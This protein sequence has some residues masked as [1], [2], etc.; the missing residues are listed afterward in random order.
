MNE[1]MTGAEIVLKSLLERFY[2]ISRIF[3]LIYA[4]RGFP[5]YSCTLYGIVEKPAPKMLLIREPAENNPYGLICTFR[6]CSRTRL[7]QV[8]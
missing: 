3:L 1:Q 8:P 5:I 6:I 2:N 4:L 7:K